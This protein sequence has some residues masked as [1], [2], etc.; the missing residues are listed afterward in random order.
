VLAAL[1][2]GETGAN[3]FTSANYAALS[4]VENDMEVSLCAGAEAP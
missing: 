4:S 3:G 1:I 2:A